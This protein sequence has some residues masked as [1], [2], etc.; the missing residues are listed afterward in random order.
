MS[1]W[2]LIALLFAIPENEHLRYAVNW[3]SGLA[4]GEAQLRTVPKQGNRE[5]ELVIDAGVPGF[6]VTDK[7]RSIATVAMCSIEFEKDLLHGKRSIKETTTFDSARGVAVRETKGGG[8]KTETPI[9]PCA[10]DAL[11]FFGVRSR[12]TCEG[13]RAFVADYLLSAQRTASG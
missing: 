2:I 3:P 5:M 4:L 12:R 8:G 7:Y 10:K 1:V 9:G 13:P 11:S 6:P